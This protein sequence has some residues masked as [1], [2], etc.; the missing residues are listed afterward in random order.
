MK[1]ILTLIAAV[2][3]VIPLM[4]IGN[5]SGKT[6]DDA[7]DFTWDTPMYQDGGTKAVWYRVDLA[8]L[9]EQDSPVL[10]LY[11]TNVNSE[12]SAVVEMIATVAGQTETKTAGAGERTGDGRN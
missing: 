8:P 12:G 2:M 4:A 6:K 11:L 7:I 9:Y 5:N 10:N 3:M 1:K